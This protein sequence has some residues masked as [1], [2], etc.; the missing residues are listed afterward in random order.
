M[1]WMENRTRVVPKGIIENALIKVGKFI[2]PTDFIILE[3]EANYRVPI[4]LGYPF[5][6]IWE[7]LID[8]RED[9]LKVRLNNEEVVFRVYKAHNTPSQYKY[10]FMIIDMEVDKCRGEVQTFIY[11]FELPYEVAQINN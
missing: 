1:L 8:V 10:L 9:T 6:S 2:S 5:L 4:I 3:Y 7:T 11:L